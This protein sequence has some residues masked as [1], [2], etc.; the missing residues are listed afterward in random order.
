MEVEIVVQ[1]A[2]VR[3]LLDRAPAQVD[4]A[5]RGAMTDATTWLQRQM[6]T[7][8]PQRTGSAYRRTGTLGRSWARTVSDEAGAIVGRVT[9]S[10][11]IAPY[12]RL[13]QDRTRQATV[14]RGR[15]QTAQDVAERSRGQINDMFAARIRAA[16]G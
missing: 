2:Q 13:V 8:P 9:S 7:Y 14:H 3:A 1:D 12:N 10:G 15:W 6:Q 16:I 11:N 5:L 4:R